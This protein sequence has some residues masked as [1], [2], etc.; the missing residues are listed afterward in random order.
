MDFKPTTERQRELL[1]Q[2]LL[3]R[4]FSYTDRLDKVLRDQDL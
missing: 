2:M 1:N 3:A 4:G